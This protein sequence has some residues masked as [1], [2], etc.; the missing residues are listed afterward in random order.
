MKN[1]SLLLLT[2]VIALQSLAQKDSTVTKRDRKKD[3]LLETAMGNIWVR[4]S[5]STPLHRIIF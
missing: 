2:C 5:D 1:I 3:V 4:L